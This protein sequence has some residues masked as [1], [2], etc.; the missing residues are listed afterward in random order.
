MTECDQETDPIKK[1]SCRDR[2]YEYVNQFTSCTSQACKD[3]LKTDYERY[4]S[5]IDECKAKNSASEQEVCKDQ[6]NA[7]IEELKA[8]ESLTGAALQSCEGNAEYNV[9]TTVCQDKKECPSGESYNCKT[10]NCLSQKSSD[11]LRTTYL[12]CVMQTT[13]ELQAQCMENLEDTA[14]A[15]STLESD[16]E[17]ATNDFASA[18][19]TGAMAAGLGSAAGMISGLL[20]V[21]KGAKVCASSGILVI[22]GMLALFNEV[23]H[24]KEVEARMKALQAEYQAKVGAM[25]RNSYEYQRVSFEYAIKGYNEMAKAYK[26]KGKN[27][28]IIMGV[29]GLAAAIAGME[30]ALAQAMPIMPCNAGAAGMNLAGGALM[31]GMAAGLNGKAKSAAA[32]HTAKANELQ[33]LIDEFDKFHTKGGID[34][35]A[36]ALMQDPTT[37][38]AANLTEISSPQ[39]DSQVKDLVAEQTAQGN[40]KS[41]VAGNG[42]PDLA[43]NCISTNSCASVDIGI[44]LTGTTSQIAQQKESYDTLNKENAIGSLATNFNQFAV[45]KQGF[46]KLMDSQEKLS[47][48]RVD[49][50]RK[51]I[52][53]YNKANPTKPISLSASNTGLKGQ[54]GLSTL[55]GLNMETGKATGALANTKDELKKEKAIL[56]TSRP[57]KMMNF[58]NKMINGKMDFIFK[59]DKNNLLTIDEVQN[60]SAKD[61][62]PTQDKS[63]LTTSSLAPL[64]AKDVNKNRDANLFEIISERYHRRFFRSAKSL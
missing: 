23:N 34:Q 44:S 2:V 8:C 35:N 49:A 30:L 54:N 55:P 60:D 58:N 59:D 31:L 57:G 36:I 50:G 29:G 16:L 18:A 56:A 47:G 33:T 24:S 51:A 4:K 19:K 9:A 52:E 39:Y 13:E 45:G 1:V 37:I 40:D 20:S 38:L 3:E 10:K 64:N 61:T 46:T 41:C 5:S 48:R 15:G 62:D 43:C 12:E 25:D 63:T 17:S 6:V 42:S 21:G 27:Y 11:E 14:D 22:G 7:Y 28:A 32:S 26:E 53:A